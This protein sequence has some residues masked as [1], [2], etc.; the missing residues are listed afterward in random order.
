MGRELIFIYTVTQVPD[1]VEGLRDE[2]LPAKARVD[3]H[4]TYDIDLVEQ[5]E[6]RFD[7]GVRIQGNARAHAKRTDLL[8][9]AVQMPA[10]LQVDRQIIGSGG[11]ESLGLS[12]RPF[13][14]EMSVEDLVSRL[15]QAR[16]QG[17]CETEIR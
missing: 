3:T 6:E 15:K 4:D 17:L 13:D 9:V 11:L 14:H 7:R 16:N 2:A 8:Q 5:V 1:A 10:G 12:L